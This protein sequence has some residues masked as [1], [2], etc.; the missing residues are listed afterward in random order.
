MSLTTQLPPVRWGVFGTANIALKKVIPAMQRSTLSSIV[1]I[2]SRDRQKAEEAARSLGIPRVYGSYEELL[3]DA[4]IE[5]VYNPLPNHLHVPWS[6]R[7]A[8]AGKHVLCEKPLALTAQEAREL[9]A[10]RKNT[11]VQIAEAFMVRAHPQWI[12]V[13][14]MVHGDEIGELRLIAGHFSYF[15]RDADDIRSHVEYGGGALLDI[16]CYP[17]TLSRWIFNSEPEAVIAL[18]ERDPDLAIDRLTSALLRFP[19]GQASF[20]CAGQLVPYQRMH[21]FGTRGRIEVEIPFNAPPERSCR[22]F[23]D[24]GRD[25]TGASIQALTFPAVD[26]YTLQGDRFSEAVRGWAS[27]PVGVDDAVANMAVIDALFRSAET[28]QWEAPAAFA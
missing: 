1:A 2:A 23:V 27:V 14:Q 16:G 11:G 26:Q 13:V 9:N 20:T 22:V 28:Q 21:L 5:A 7:A 17:I 19:S 3:D 6:I 10:A 12:K 4:E 18:I 24:D 25:L 15:K 8:N